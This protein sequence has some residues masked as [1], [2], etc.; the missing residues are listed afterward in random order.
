VGEWLKEP[1][2]FKLTLGNL[3]CWFSARI[4]TSLILSLAVLHRVF[5]VATKHHYQKASFSRKGFI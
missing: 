4:V 5:I 2:V 3:S 1:S